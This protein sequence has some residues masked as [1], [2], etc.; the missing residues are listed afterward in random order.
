MQCLMAEKESDVPL[1]SLPVLA[2]QIGEN[3]FHA[4]KN[5]PRIC[6][7]PPSD[8]PCLV[9][10]KPPEADM[11]RKLFGPE[12]LMDHFVILPPGP[13]F[14]FC[15][16]D[17]AHQRSFLLQVLKTKTIIHRV[18]KYIKMDCKKPICINFILA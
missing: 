9:P 18:P 11:T 7:L 12:L 6:C 5:M 10:V 14:E 17:P 2:G 16:T 3:W 4:Y 13:G 1:L 8:S 15:I